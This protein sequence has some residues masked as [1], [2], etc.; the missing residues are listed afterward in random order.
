M[1]CLYSNLTFLNSTIVA[2]SRPMN[3]GTILKSNSQGNY[4]F[5]HS[6]FVYIYY[7]INN[8]LKMKVRNKKTRLI[9]YFF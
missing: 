2:D 7:F 8:K 3:S 9:I 6:I 1:I 4:Y 5:I